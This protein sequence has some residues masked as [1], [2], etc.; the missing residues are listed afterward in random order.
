MSRRWKW[1]RARY[2]RARKLSRLMGRLEG[3]PAICPPLLQ[4]HSD[5]MRPLWQQPGDPMAPGDYRTL[6]YRLAEFK[7]DCDDIPF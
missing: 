6:R 7:G 3:G 4:R 5:L 1:T 2:E